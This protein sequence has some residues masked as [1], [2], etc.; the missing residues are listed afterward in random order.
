MYASGVRTFVEVGPG[1]TLTGLV[2][3]ILAGH[4]HGRLDR[5]GGHGLTGLQEGLG[6]PAVHGVPPGPDG[7]RGRR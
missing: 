7:A 5:P 3:R 4:T 1:T 2:G 6:R